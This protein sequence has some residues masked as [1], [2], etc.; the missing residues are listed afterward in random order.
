M[1]AE[2]APK[3]RGP[4]SWPLGRIAFLVV[5][6]VAIFL[7][8][9]SCQTEG[10]DLTQEQAIAIASEEVDFEPDRVVVRLLRRGL[11]FTP[12]W[13]VSLSQEREGG[14]FENVIV[15]TVNA[16]TGEVVDVRRG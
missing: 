6:L 14:G 1:D 7:V 8:S 13:A 10:I 16:S 3:A 5:L 11:N 4:R 15:V 9:R 2:S 12:H